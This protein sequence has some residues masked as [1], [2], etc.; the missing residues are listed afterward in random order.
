MRVLPLT[1]LAKEGPQARA[2]LA[3]M[4]QCGY[5]PKKIVLMIGRNHPVTRK[6][7]FPRLP[8]RWRVRLAERIHESSCNFWPRKIRASHPFLFE[9]T[10][11]EL[12]KSMD[13][14]RDLLDEIA[15]PFAYERYA[16]NVRRVF[17]VGLS[18]PLIQEELAALAPCPVLFTGGGIL[19]RNLLDLPGVRFLHVHPGFLPHVRGADGLLWSILVRGKPGASCF[20]MASGI[21]TGD[22]ITAQDYAPMAIQLSKESRPDDQVLYRALFSY[23]DPL[24]RAHMLVSNVLDKHHDLGK[25][26]ASPQNSSAGLTYHF[27]HP[28]LKRKALQILYR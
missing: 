17:V 10:A 13:G 3:R 5:R 28:R 27:M 15:G 19:R 1:V 26:P 4:R 12:A 6:P 11:R 2:Y 23:L 8:R 20:Y 7:I 24:L 16:E 9:A 21:D 22:I 25:A 14:P 18:D